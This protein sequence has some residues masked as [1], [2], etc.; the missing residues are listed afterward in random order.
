MWSV[1]LRTDMNNERCIGT[2]VIHVQCTS[3]LEFH[4]N[5]T[6]GF[7]LKWQRNKREGRIS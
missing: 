7:M 1:I 4:E 2:C 6:I 5:A 3:N